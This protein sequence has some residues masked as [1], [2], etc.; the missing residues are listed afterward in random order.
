MHGVKDG[1]FSTYTILILLTNFSFKYKSLEIILELLNTKAK[2]FTTLIKLHRL[3]VEQEKTLQC[4]HHT[5][6]TAQHFKFPQQNVLS[7]LVC[8]IDL[9]NGKTPRGSTRV[10]QFPNR[11]TYM[12]INV[13]NM[14]RHSPVWRTVSGSN[15]GRLLL[16]EDLWV[17]TYKLEKNQE[18]F[19]GAT[20]QT[21]RFVCRDKHAGIAQCAIV[22]RL[23]HLELF[24]FYKVSV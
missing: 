10:S 6:G 22:N 8:Q 2:F 19:C 17:R 4:W 24:F 12:H 16:S 23:K 11:R 21:R 13:D 1:Q 5:L 14:C 9:K 18:S 15:E 3:T 20:R 7:Q